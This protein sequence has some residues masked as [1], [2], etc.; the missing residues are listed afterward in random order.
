MV[1][2]LLIV[3]GLALCLSHNAYPVGAQDATANEATGDI[4]ELFRQWK[5]LDVELAQKAADFKA[6]S[7]TEARAD[8][9]GQY[10]ALVQ[11][12]QA[13]VKKI[14][15]KA[16]QSLGKDSLDETTSKL[17]VGIIMN[18]STFGRHNDAILL[19]DQYIAAGGE[20]KFLE[21][22][23]RSDRLSISSKELMEELYLRFQQS[24]ED[25]LPRV[26]VETSK[27]DLVVELFEEEAP[28]TV[29]NFVSLV[30]NNF[31]D[32]LKFHRVIE[33]FVAQ[34]GDPQGNGSGGPGYTI[35]CEC[36]TPEARGHFIGS[37][38]M[39]H[40][41]KDTGGSQF[42][43]CFDRQSTSILDG[44]HTVFGRVIE[45]IE[46]LDRLSRNATMRAPIPNTDTDIIKKMVVVRKRDHKYVPKKMGEEQTE[47]EVETPPVQPTT[48][49]QDTAVDPAKKTSDE[50]SEGDG[51]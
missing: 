2:Q 50:E 33:G 18:D 51:V 29:A 20:G 3:F 22:A 11:Q 37:L 13:L 25:N 47:E 42:F 31:Y 24:Q 38:S 15:N 49:N 36:S 19:G 43:I 9:R 34:G 28:N 6:T 40:A 10:E 4:Q 14:R 32:G 45:G 5:E 23:A 44:K 1:R 16:M 48:G 8:I 7:E 46:V 21:T 26:K 35:A 30:E 27:G 17:I 12:S 39:A 41:G